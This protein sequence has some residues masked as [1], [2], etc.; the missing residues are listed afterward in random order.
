AHP[1]P[2]LL[3][4]REASCRGGVRAPP[5]EARKLSRARRPRRPRSGC[6]GTRGHRPRARCPRRGTCSAGIRRPDRGASVTSAAAHAKINLALVVGPRRGD[7]FHEIATVL[8]R[9]ELADTV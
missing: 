6:G 5:Q 8:Q 1:A 9:I 4:A 2:G 3:R 7:G